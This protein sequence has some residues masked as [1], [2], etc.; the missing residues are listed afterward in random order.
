MTSAFA[1]ESFHEAPSGGF[2]VLAAA[3][4]DPAAGDVAREA[5]REILGKRRTGKLHWNE[6][7]KQERRNAAKIVAGLP[8][9]H[10]VA[11]GAPVP[12]RRQERARAKCLE[13]LIFE[14]HGYGVSHL[15]IE[16]RS[17][18]LNLRDIATVAG[19]R[20]KLPKGA[21]L[22]VDHQ[23]G[24]EPLFWVADIVAGAVRAHR[25]GQ[26]SY[27]QDLDNCVYEIEVVTGC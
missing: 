9:F 15:V 26:P 21:R 20:F 4:F 2:Y 8:G 22:H 24:T 23:T 25:E 1:D 19:M 3:M 13:R 16:A 11:L 12:I 10:V 17:H 6:M 27:R 18:Q 5:M 7:D 14:L